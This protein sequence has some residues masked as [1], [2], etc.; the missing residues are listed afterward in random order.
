MYKTRQSYFQMASLSKLFLLFLISTFITSCNHSNLEKK[1]EVILATVGNE[2]ITVSDFR[3]NYEFGLPHLKVEPDRKLSYLT[4]MIYEKILSLEG[5]KLGFDK[6]SKVKKLESELLDELLI[7]ELFKKNVNSKIKIK[8][9]EV[10]QAILKSQVS[11]KMNYWF[12]TDIDQAKFIRKEIL[13]NGF[14]NTISKILKSNPEIKLK[15]KDFETDYLTWLEIE[16]EIL[17]KI[18]NLS[19]N[20]V[21][22][23]IKIGKGYFLYQIKDIRRQPISDYSIKE[24]Y[25]RFRQI[26]YYRKLKKEAGKFVA[27]VM[28]PKNVVTKGKVLYELTYAFLTWRQ[29]TLKPNFKDYIKNHYNFLL[30]QT[31]TTYDD[32]KWTV[33]D[34]LNKFNPSK[35][36]NHSTNKEKIG[37]EIAKQIALSI[38][39]KEFTKLAY[40]SG[41]KKNESVKKQLK[42]WRDKWVYNEMRGS[43]LRNNKISDDEAKQFFENN[44]SLFQ[45]NANKVPK[46]NEFKNTAKKFAY[47][48]KA[49]KILFNKI[50]SLKKIYPIHINKAV[51]DTITTIDFE[52]S[53]WQSLQVFK[54]SSNR[55][56]VPIVD[57]A[58]KIK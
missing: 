25:E 10:K 42:E 19:L 39:D 52:K 13:K 34:F 41:L 48:Q 55:L 15:S 40:E 58:W 47:I 21:S 44:I 17:D 5:Y 38:R 49:E 27:S 20:E 50:D 6:S 18:K 57:P 9:E 46:Y 54:R 51:L 30:S 31:L 12:E 37:G 26:L 53:R 23:P 8:P 16:P 33:A 7:E 11:W 14:E 1:K 35:I 29:D 36:K 32:K 43:Y 24:K 3:R 45:I 56:A 22:E 28:K 4:Y 2:K